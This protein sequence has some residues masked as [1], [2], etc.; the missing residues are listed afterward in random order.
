MATTRLITPSPLFDTLENLRDQSKLPYMNL[1]IDYEIAQADFLHARSF[2]LS[3]AGGEAT[4][5]TYRREIER[6]IQWSWL[7]AHKSIKDLKRADIESYME[8]C[9]KPPKSWIATEQV[10]RFITLNAERQPNPKWRPFVAIP[11]LKPRV[12]INKS[13]KEEYSLSQSAIQ[14]VFAVSSSFYNYL[15]QEDYAPLNPIA[16]VRQKSRFIRKQQGKRPIRRLSE[17]QWNYVIETAEQMA[18]QNPIHERTLFVM[19]ALYTLYLRISELAA[20]TRWT[21]IMGHFHTDSEQNWWFTTVGKG[22]KERDISVSVAML[23]AL[24]RYRKYLGLSTLPTPGES[25]PLLTKTL[26]NGPITSTRHIRRIVQDCFDTAVTRLQTDGHHEEAEQL[27]V[28]TVHWLRHT[29][30]S[31][32][33][34]HRPREHVRD[35]AGHSSSAI[36]DRYI[37]IDLK[38]RHASGRNKPLK[39]KEPDFL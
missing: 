37:D 38:A 7:I 32:D 29:G 16:Q 31:D 30:I 5:N 9:L 28:V 2:L 27:K 21:P 33:V 18:A 12:S 15:L 36:T 25:T 19:S 10:S 6:L 17:L 26:G 3:Y 39:P 11:N 4:F 20:S 8:F 34:K 35:D 14:A 22:N 24:K 1:S 13:S 23:N